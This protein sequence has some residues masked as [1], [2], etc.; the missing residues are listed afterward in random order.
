MHPSPFEQISAGTLSIFDTVGAIVSPKSDVRLQHMSGPVMMLRVYYVMFENKEGWR[1]ALWF[2]VVLNVNLALL[3]L[4]P[5]PV[6]DGGHITLALVEAV[7]RRPV[8]IRV[9]EVVQ[10]AC[11]VLIIGFM[12]YI[13]FFDVQ[14]L[15]GSR[16]DTPRFSPKATPSAHER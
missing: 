15:F 13:A 8:N 9:L 5:I 11:A 16:R 4:L 10:T 2:S 7:R 1:M 3:N 12:L 14:D 6:L